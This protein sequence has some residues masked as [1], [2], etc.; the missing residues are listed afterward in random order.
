MHEEAAALGS[1]SLAGSAHGAMGV[2]D[3]IESGRRAA[4]NLIAQRFGPKPVRFAR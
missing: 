1:L 2:S 4:E 3:C